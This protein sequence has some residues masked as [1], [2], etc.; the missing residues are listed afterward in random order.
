[1]T[2]CW[3]V[4]RRRPLA[5]SRGCSTRR[6]RDYTVCWGR[7]GLLH[8]CADRRLRP[9]PDDDALLAD[10]AALQIGERRLRL[11]EKRRIVIE[12]ASHVY[13]MFRMLEYRPQVVAAALLS[14]KALVGTLLAKSHPPLERSLTDEARLV[15]VNGREPQA[16]D[17]LLG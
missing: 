3:L 10:I 7:G 4:A 16:Q 14:W 11:S 8:S 1:V 9:H 5:S 6:S 15:R 2:R 17:R 13:G 12:G